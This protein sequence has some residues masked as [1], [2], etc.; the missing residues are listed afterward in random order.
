MRSIERFV[1]GTSVAA[2][3]A[4]LL[5]TGLFPAA[6][7]AAPV[8]CRAQ[9]ARAIQG[10]AMDI[11]QA[12]TFTVDVTTKKAYRIG[13]KATIDAVVTRPAHRDPLQA[14]P[15][16]D[17]PASA[18]ADGVNVGIGIHV[19]DV[20]VPGFGVTDENGKVTVT[21][22]LPKY[23]KSGSASIDAYAWKI[24]VDSPCLTLEEDG[25][26]HVD[27]AFKVSL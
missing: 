10:N 13:G 22:K 11:V 26:T 2:A 8:P 12:R 5:I 18:P 25:F 21:I 20:F 16:F 6:A 15:E 14:G 17:P 3:L 9:A 23:M 27:N 4:G 24:A 7:S 1:K 19:G